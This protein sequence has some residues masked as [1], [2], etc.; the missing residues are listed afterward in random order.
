MQS[1]LNTQKSIDVICDTT[2]RKKS[3]QS[4]LL[5]L[6]R[7]WQN[8]IPMHDGKKKN[9]KNLSTKKQKGTSST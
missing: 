7:L 5:R 4:Y 3:I 1:W 2:E 6:K 9:P 8:L